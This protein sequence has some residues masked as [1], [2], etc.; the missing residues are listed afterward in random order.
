M[1]LGVC[2][3]GYGARVGLLSCEEWNEEMALNG[4][5]EVSSLHGRRL[6]VAWSILL[7]PIT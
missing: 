2:I 7:P 4:G 5:K 1:V 6:G 3:L